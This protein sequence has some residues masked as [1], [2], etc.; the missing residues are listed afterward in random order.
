MMLSFRKYFK[1]FIFY[2]PEYLDKIGLDINEN[3][4]F[5]IKNRKKKKKI[6][7]ITTII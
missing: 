3:L 1:N 6:T 7:P 2:A 5:S 4:T